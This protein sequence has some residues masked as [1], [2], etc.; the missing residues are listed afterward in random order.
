M[1]ISKS[2]GLIRGENGLTDTQKNRWKDIKNDTGSVH[3]YT[4]RPKG[5]YCKLN[6]SEEI[7][8]KTLH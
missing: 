5:T 6:F 4:T 3:N 8:Q 1:S 7:L 2:N